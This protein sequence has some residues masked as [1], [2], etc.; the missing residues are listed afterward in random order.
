MPSVTVDLDDLEALVFATG[1]IKQ[2]DSLLAARRGDPFVVPYLA[3]TD[4]H[5]RCAEAARFARR[6]ENQDVVTKWD[7]P[8]TEEEAE[9]LLKLGA[10]VNRV[11]PDERL[12]VPAIDTL[13]AKGCV[14]LGHFVDGVLWGG[15]P[16]PEIQVDPKAFAVKITPCGQA[17][18]EA[19]KKA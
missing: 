8:L 15:K 1:A 19:L 11:S 3:R 18:L 6:A 12:K 17:K 4:A 14:V 10:D 9:V 13:M 7:E 5:D 16:T 2:I